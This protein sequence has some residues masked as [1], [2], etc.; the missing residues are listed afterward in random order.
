MCCSK[1]LAVELAAAVD[2]PGI[3]E[4]Q[5]VKIAEWVLDN[6][7]VL[8]QKLLPPQILPVLRASS[9]QDL[10][11]LRPKLAQVLLASMSK[12]PLGAYVAWML[13]F[14]KP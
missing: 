7:V 9:T 1:K 5:E 12:A 8:A 6:T 3:N 13:P 2:I 4:E 14:P 10:D 11:A